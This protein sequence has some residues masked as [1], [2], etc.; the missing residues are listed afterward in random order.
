MHRLYVVFVLI[1]AHSN[2][3]VVFSFLV[4]ITSHMTRVV[5]VDP[6]WYDCNG[7]LFDHYLLTQTVHERRHFLWSSSIPDCGNVAVIVF[8]LAYVYVLREIHGIRRYPLA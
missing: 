1:P 7:L 5:F 8:F 4:L 3:A 6:R 2:I